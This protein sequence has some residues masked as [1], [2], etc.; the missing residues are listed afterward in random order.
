MKKLKKEHIAWMDTILSLWKTQHELEI[1]LSTM[2]RL[3][4]LK[5]NYW[6]GAVIFIIGIILNYGSLLL[7]WWG[8]L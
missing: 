3:D 8:I 5:R 7:R 6:L 4:N 2:D 1:Y